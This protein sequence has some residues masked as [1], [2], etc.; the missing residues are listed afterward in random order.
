M[1]PRYLKLCELAC[2]RY[3]ASEAMRRRRPRQAARVRAF[4]ANPRRHHPSR[5]WAPV[6][7][8]PRRPIDE[9]PAEVLRAV[10]AGLRR[11]VVVP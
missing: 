1:A 5:S 8:S 9:V 7:P 2:T 10:L 3:L 6:A 4:A 11:L